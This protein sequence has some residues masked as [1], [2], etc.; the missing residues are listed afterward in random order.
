MHLAS[1]GH[2]IVG[3]STYS[4]SHGLG[5]DVG[6]I[7]LVDGGES[8]SGDPPTGGFEQRIPSLPIV[9]DATYTYG[10]G[11]AAYT[12]QA[13]GSN[14]KSTAPTSAGSPDSTHHGVSSCAPRSEDAAHAAALPGRLEG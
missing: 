5:Q 7:G 8:S 13:N 14:T 9:G 10:E 12:Y 4:C 6:A 2:P 3:D 1:I 11:A